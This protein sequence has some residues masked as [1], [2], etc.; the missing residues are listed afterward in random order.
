M[1]ADAGIQSQGLVVRGREA[2][3]A[4]GIRRD[5]TQSPNQ[6]GGLLPI[7]QIGKW[8]LRDHVLAQVI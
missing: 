8:R 2:G 4:A 7:S 6:G 1:L 3:L 5:L